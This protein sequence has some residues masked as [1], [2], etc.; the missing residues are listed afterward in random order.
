MTTDSRKMK[1]KNRLVSYKNWLTCK[2]HKNK[3]RFWTKSTGTIVLLLVACLS[4]YWRRSWHRKLYW[5]HVSSGHSL[6]NK[7]YFNDRL[8]AHTDSFPWFG[9]DSLQWLDRPLLGLSQQFLNEFEI[10]TWEWGYLR[11]YGGFPANSTV[12]VIDIIFF[13]HEY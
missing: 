12:R 2:K 8:R 9:L 10:E 7:Q 5:K 4:L 3:M 1:V 13:I 6:F 11:I